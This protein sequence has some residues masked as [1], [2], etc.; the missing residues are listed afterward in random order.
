MARERMK[1]PRLRL[2][3]ALDLPDPVL[4]RITDWQEEAFAGRSDLRVTPRFSLHVTL[5]FLGYQAE[6]D[7]D[8]IAELAFADGGGPFQLQPT[9]LTEVPPRRPR[10]YALGLEDEGEAL[11]NFQAV[12]SERLKEGGLYE[13]EKRPFWPHLTVARFK[14]TERHR[15]G[16]GARGGTRRSARGPAAAPEPMPEFPEE[17]TK[18]F[19]ASRL[20]LYKSELRPRGAVYEPLVRVQAEGAKAA[21]KAKTG[22]KE[23]EAEAE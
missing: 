11:G 9:E 21:T 16:G 1:S 19:E 10:L 20:T 14:Q 6:K 2:F 5:V 3:V 22:G 13:P 4:D 17:L 8:R 12:A 23:S 15:T 18:A 7:V